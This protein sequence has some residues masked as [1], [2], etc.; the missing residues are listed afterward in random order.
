MEQIAVLSDV[1]GNMT[2]FEAVLADIDGRGIDRVFNLGDLFGKGPNGAA[3][4]AATRD[5]CEATVRG[6]WDELVLVPFEEASPTL[7]WWLDEMSPEDRDWLRALPFSVDL[8]LGGTAIRL[9]HASSNNVSHRIHRRHTEG[10]FRSMFENTEATGSG[11]IPDIVV[12]GDIHNAYTRT[13]GDKTLVNAGSVGNPLDEPT[14]SYVII[15]ATPAG[16]AREIV[17][18]P[19]DI[20]REIAVAA[21]RGMPE[22]EPYAVELRTS[23]YRGLQGRDPG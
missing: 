10:E 23:V 20:E 18:V 17:R 6:N 13:V 9:F 22:L 19:Y 4:I 15:T 16:P 12:Y 3:A 11:P 7:R 8:E 14:A 2:A 5:R 21:A 1:H